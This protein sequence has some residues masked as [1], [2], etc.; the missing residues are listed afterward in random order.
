MTKKARKYARFRRFMVP[1]FL[2]FFADLWYT[3]CM[4]TNDKQPLFTEEQLQNMKPEHLREIVR[5][6]KQQMK[7]MD[8]Q[9]KQSQEQLKLKQE[10][11]I[12]LEFMNAMLNDRLALAQKQRF[13]S[14]SEK[15]QDGYEQ[16]SFVFNEVEDKANEQ[17]HVEPEY[18]DIHPAAYKRKKSSGKKEQD[19]SAFPIVR[20]EH[21][22]IG[23]DRKC[24]ECG[25]KRKVVTTETHRYL[26]F[27][28]ARFETVEEVVYVYS[29]PVC[30]T[31]IRAPKVPS[32]L[33]GSIAT[34]SLVAAI[35]NGKYVNGLPLY[36]QSQEFKR[37][38]LN[39]E[40]KTMAN[41]VIRCGEDFLYPL[42]DRMKAIL[43]ESR[44]IH[45]DETRIQVLDEPDQK[46]ETANWMW[47]YMTDEYSESPQMVLFQYE[48]TRGGYHPKEFLAGYHGYL[49]T[50]GYQV[51][52]G[53]PE[54]IIVTGC[55][56]HAR[57]R[58]DKCLTILKRDFTKEQIRG[59][60]A[61]EAMKRIALLYKVEDLIRDK[62]PEER[63]QE[64]QKQSKPLMDALFEWLHS[65]KTD[66]LDRKSLIGDAILYT[67]GQEEYLRRYLDDGHLQIDNNS[68]ERAQKTFAIGRRAWLFSKSIRGAEISAVIY[69]ITETARLHGLKPYSYLTYVMETMLLR[70]SDTDHSFIDDL[71]PWSPNLPEECSML[72]EHK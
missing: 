38:G 31:M 22:L 25:A 44:Y 8:T 41:W 14:S 6:Q 15:Y 33:K 35:M 21:K 56:A 24:P 58:F 19:L 30:E 13:G 67:L 69:S 23:D 71:L 53:L 64:R 1:V 39:L 50:D 59:T 12:E 62:T 2:A 70:R 3:I 54:E 16:L 66:D 61:D 26:R 60:I 10:Q 65:L 68:C 43:L 37:Y 42:Y 7:K 45:C 11:I 63:Y 52:H 51:Y 48:R 27:I 20:V 47:V 57:R 9:I 32:L 55:L 4:K 5:L 18:E 72:I 17:S 46:A 34:P 49:T 28:P 29:C 40:D 36:R